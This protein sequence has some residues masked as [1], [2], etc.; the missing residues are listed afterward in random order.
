M[1]YP[2]KLHRRIPKTRATTCTGG[3]FNPG[4]TG[5]VSTDDP[6]EELCFKCLEKHVHRLEA[7]LMEAI[8]QLMR[9]RRAVK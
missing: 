9:Y 3:A 6:D 8:E 4:C 5:F 1:T 2:F 7:N